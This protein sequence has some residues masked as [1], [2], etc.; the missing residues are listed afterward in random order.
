MAARSPLGGKRIGLLTHSASR[1]G[2]G[3]FE[4][5]A[6]Q[7]AM[8]CQLGAQPVVVALRDSHSHADRERFAGA[9]LLHAPRIGPR[10]FG[11]SP[12]L[13]A[14]LEAARLDL[15]HL[16]GV[17]TYPSRAATL[18]ARRTGRPYLVSPHGMLDRWITRRSRWKK[19]LAR[20]GYEWDSWS[21]A[22]AFH[23]LT[24]REAGDIIRES[25]RSRLVVIAN[26][27]P[28]PAP[29]PTAMPDPKVLYLGR[30][31]PKKNLG[32][33]IAGWSLLDASGAL[34]P[35]ASLILAGWGEQRH[36]AELERLL[37][38]APASVC[39]VGP[40]F[41]ADKARLLAGARFL[42]LPSHSEGLPMVVLEAW[43][44][45]TPV[46]MTRECNLPEGFAASAAL[47]CGYQPCSIAAA[48]AAALAL[49][50]TGWRRMSQAA[51]GLAS[52]RFSARAIARQWERAYAA[53][54][55]GPETAR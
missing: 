24:E 22:S 20:H 17:W 45:G 49:D 9:E 51:H 25:G 34:P 12:R 14:L 54:L 7:A 39:F 55:A 18:W 6:A 1:L 2:G 29:R 52:G 43:A 50:P 40:R 27:G 46:L 23:A 31:H 19:A 4:A 32:A 44:A 35:G 10:L 16:H 36:V 8:L 37:A 15:L 26:P 47:D 28:E 5:V 38:R 3:V 48:L 11:Y 21:Q 42:A 30:I 41:G 13:L 33:L 53:L